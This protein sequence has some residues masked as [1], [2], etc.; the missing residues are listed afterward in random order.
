M[1][2]PGISSPFCKGSSVFMGEMIK[3]SL[4]L[5]SNKRKGWREADGDI[6][7]S[8]VALSD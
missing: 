5:A 2:S 7:E 6:G 3:K 8:R 4:G 1:E